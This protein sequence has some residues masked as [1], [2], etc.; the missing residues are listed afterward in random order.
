[1]G[2]TQEALVYGGAIGHSPGGN[3]MGRR[4]LSMLV[5]IVMVVLLLVT[6]AS[7]QETNPAPAATVVVLVDLSGSLTED[8]IAQEVRAAGIL[9]TLPGVELYIIGFASQGSLPATVVVCEPG[10]DLTE[11]TLALVPR[12]NSEGNDTDHAAALSAAADVFSSSTATDGPKIVL[13]L[14]DGEYDPSGSGAPTDAEQAALAEGLNELVSTGASVWPL[15]FGR[16]TRTELD[17]LAVAAPDSCKEPRGLLV[18]LA[19]QVPAAAGKIIADATCSAA[20]EGER[21]TVAPDTELVIVTYAEDELQEGTITVRTRT[22]GREQITC[23]FDTV[24]AVWTC[25]IPTDTLGPGAWKIAPVP[26]QYPVPYQQAT[27]VASPETTTT[28]QTP[29]TTTPAP[30][31]TAGETAAT[32]LAPVEAASTTTQTPAGDD[33]GFPLQLVLVGVVGSAILAGVILWS[34]RS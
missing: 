19:K 22:D 24:A 9:N 28:V 14:T 11:C 7:A 33:T 25:E 30:S 13:F 15:G 21:L 31:T 4:V 3:T 8:D 12:T 10:E 18:R 16:A 32:T 29:S 17:A 20:F 34:R 27:G 5:G 26:I 6:A 1:M 23:L 2:P